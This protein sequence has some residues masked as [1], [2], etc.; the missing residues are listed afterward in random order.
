MREESV[1]KI[2]PIGVD[3]ANDVSSHGTL[4]GLSIDKWERERTAN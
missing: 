2:N 1:I 4:E 3:E